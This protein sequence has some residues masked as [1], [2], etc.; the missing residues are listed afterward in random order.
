MSAAFAWKASGHPLSLAALCCLVALQ[1]CEKQTTNSPVA[2][3]PRASQVSQIKVQPAA[4][5]QLVIKTE[6][7]EFD[8]SQ[9]G[10]AREIFSTSDI[11]GG[12]I[13]I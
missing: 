7:A 6:T 2:S 10:Q 8:V 13:S 9:Q 11:K 1:G 5:G 12:R 4:A 3:A